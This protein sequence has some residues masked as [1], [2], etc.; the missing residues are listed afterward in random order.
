VKREEGISLAEHNGKIYYQKLLLMSEV[1]LEFISLL[2][3][4]HIFMTYVAQH[5]AQTH[6]LHPYELL[7]V[8]DL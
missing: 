7:L 1:G 4:Y 5:L 8:F 3:I 6:F 2:S